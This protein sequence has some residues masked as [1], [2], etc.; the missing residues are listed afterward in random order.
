LFQEGIAG[1]QELR[2]T[3]DHEPGRH[4]V[5]GAIIHKCQPSKLKAIFTMTCNVKSDKASTNPSFDIHQHVAE[6]RLPHADRPADRAT[7]SGHGGVSPHHRQQRAGKIRI[8]SS[9]YLYLAELVCRIF[10][11]SYDAWE[12]ADLVWGE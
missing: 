3:T 4:F 5:L 1:I 10:R 7:C 11:G 12:V 2:A 6:E 9:A 8:L